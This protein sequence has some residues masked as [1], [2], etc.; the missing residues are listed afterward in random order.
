MVTCVYLLNNIYLKRYES[1]R[2]AAVFSTQSRNANA[3]PHKGWRNAPKLYN[4]FAPIFVPYTPNIGAER[5]AAKLAMPN[6]NP[7]YERKEFEQLH[8]SS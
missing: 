2:N 3:S 1:P 8:L 5:N 6:T 4:S 7:Y